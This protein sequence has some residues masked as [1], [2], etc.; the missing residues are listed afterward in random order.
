MLLRHTSTQSNLKT[1]GTL[2]VVLKPEVL[3]ILWSLE[4]IIPQK[5]P[6]LQG[7]NYLC[8]ALFSSSIYAYSSSKAVTDL[9]V[10]A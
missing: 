9:I 7:N 1:R 4:H 5:S 6:Q 2:V 8:L 3:T 10:Y